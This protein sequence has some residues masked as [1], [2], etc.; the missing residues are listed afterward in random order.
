MIGM[1]LSREKYITGAQL[2]VRVGVCFF[3][4]ESFILLG[5]FGCNGF[6]AAVVILIWPFWSSMI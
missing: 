4:A 6:K 3:K 1:S 2:L 5:I